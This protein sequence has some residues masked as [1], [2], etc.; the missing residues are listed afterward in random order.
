MLMRIEISDMSQANM[1][2]TVEASNKKGSPDD[3][4]QFI[5][6]YKNNVFTG[7]SKHEKLLDFMKEVCEAW[8]ILRRFE[9]TVVME[10][11]G[12]AEI[13]FKGAASDSAIS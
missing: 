6:H 10:D 3:D 5:V 9:L 7:T 2:S 4:L 11:E 8:G 13:K 1:L 12:D